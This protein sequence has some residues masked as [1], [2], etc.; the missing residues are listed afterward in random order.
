MGNEFCSIQ[1]RKCLSRGA[2]RSRGAFGLGYLIQFLGLP[3]SKF[4]RND[5]QPDT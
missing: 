3:E 4:W 1:V 2:R 5:S